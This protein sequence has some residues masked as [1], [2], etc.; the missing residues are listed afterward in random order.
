[1]TTN[2]QGA[3]DTTSFERQFAQLRRNSWALFPGAVSND[4]V[5]PATSAIAHD[6]A[7]NYDRTPNK[8]VRTGT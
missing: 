7:H 1:M 6:R 3:I 2:L 5:A 4:F 8:N